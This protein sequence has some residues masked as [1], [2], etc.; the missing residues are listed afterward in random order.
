MRHNMDIETGEQFIEHLRDA[1][2]H[3][4]EPDR[5]R[6][7]PLA[8]YLGVG[9][10]VDTPS[11]LQDMLLRAIEALRPT[12]GTRLG[13]QSRRI[14][15]LLLYRY[16]Q[17]LDQQAVSDQLGISV[18][19][20]ART[21][22]SAL[23]ALAGEL[24][25]S[26]ASSAPLPPSA[27][28]LASAQ[29]SA[30]SSNDPLAELDWL[31]NALPEEAADLHAV[32]TGVLELLHHLIAQHG[33][34]IESRVAGELPGL[35]VQPVALRQIL[36]DLFTVMLTAMQRGRVYVTA[37]VQGWEVAVR[38][39]AVSS[40]PGK[41]AVVEGQARNLEVAR[42]LTT[43]CDGSLE[44]TTMEGGMSITLTL[45]ACAKVPVLV[46]DDNADA[47]QLFQRYASGSRYRVAA[48]SA[49]DEAV[50][51]AESLAPCVI[52]LDVMMPQV[53]GW[54]VLARLRAHPVTQRTPVVVCTI[55]AQEELAL[56]LGAT[57]FI[58]K[59]VTRQAFLSALDAQLA[60]KAAGSG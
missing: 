5:L 43:L 23:E 34:A 51:V 9:G 37:E 32:L 15:D 25:R 35:A 14:Y 20:L 59:P 55:L 31:K 41:T 12:S 60:R 13:S 22:N 36:I 16:I 48:T 49:P 52:I 1:L 53:D 17:Q 11:R 24:Y 2:N 57:A 7:N 19:Q 3:L 39:E 54:E 26:S 27:G 8:T 44:V 42:K 6:S 58:Q 4:H 56:S 33:S 40:T 47:L 10:H 28:P 21:Q 45:P 18:R 29:L 50:T 38:L 46:I 30:R